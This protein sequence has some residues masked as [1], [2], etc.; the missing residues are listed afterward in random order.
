MEDIRDCKGRL[1]CKIE[2]SDGSIESA[3]KRQIT[4]TRLPI[5]VD[6]IVER[7]GIRT[8]IT[9]FNANEINVVSQDLSM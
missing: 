7:N 2:P 4:K 5:G 6:F 1:V 9:R 8:V 3:Y